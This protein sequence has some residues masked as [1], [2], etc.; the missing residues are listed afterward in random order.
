MGSPFGDFSDEF[1]HGHK[2]TQASI[3]AAVTDPEKHA[4]VL[5]TVATGLQ[6]DGRQIGS[7]VAGDIK[8]LLVDSPQTARAQAAS[9]AANGFFATGILKRFAH[10]VG[11]F[12]T[13][14][15]KA[16]TDYHTRCRSMDNIARHD[17]DV[18]SGAVTYDAKAAHKS[19]YD[20]INAET[21]RPA[22]KAMET[23]IQSTITDFKNGPTN[24][25]LREL[26]KE[27][28][29]PLSAELLYPG[30]KLTPAERRQ[31]M[32]ALQ[33]QL[34][35]PPRNYAQ[36]KALLTEARA[37]GLDPKKYANTLNLYW[38]YRSAEEAGIDLDAWDPTKG[39]K[40]NEKTIE[41]VYRYYGDLFLKNPD[42]QWAGM[43]NM[44]GPSFAAGFF[45]LS[46]FRSLAEKFGH[47]PEPLRKYLP[48][49]MED[50]AHIPAD[51]LRFYETTF[52]QMQKK[53]FLD[54]GT[55]HQ[56]YMDGGLPAIEEMRKAGLIDDVTASSWTDIDSGDPARVKAGNT[57]FLMRE[58][59]DIIDRDYK[60][61][62]NH[63]GTGKAM[64]YVMTQIG[65]PSI[66]GA[67]GYP[68][69]FPLTGKFE[70]PG[71]ERIGTP[72]SFFG[73]KIPSISFDNPTQGTVTVQTPLADGNIA[74][75]EDRWG[76]IEKDTLPKY[77]ELL[78]KHPEQA[79]A[80]IAADVHDRIGNY[81]LNE[82]VDDIIK[83]LTHWKVDFD[84]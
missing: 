28:Y 57:Q 81:R 12:D 71:P 68:D 21:Y 23:A 30:L 33:K 79:R 46:T 40:Y 16:N 55:M 24:A 14:A 75:F 41:A 4:G 52:L 42:L 8:K 10:D 74:H 35:N 2:T 26:I 47:I 60:T 36:I 37:L 25:T 78:E 64:T 56:A 22:H 13:K 34:T 29:L 15:T 72:D 84:Q 69:V 73:H 80:L 45:D 50:L 11:V 31:A 77:Q 63:P 20:D 19:I 66:P 49:G 83:Q 58:Q 59:K 61:M 54:Q 39:A 3:E 5:R 27:G 17:P 1:A 43:A 38:A 51:E 82:R 32:A 6:A 76:L 44:I 53:I 7:Q 48:E 65:T 70:T 67:K 9:L 18:R 62:Y